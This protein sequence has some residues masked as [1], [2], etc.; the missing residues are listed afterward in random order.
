MDVH[1]GSMDSSST[2]ETVNATSR[3]S[4]LIATIA[5]TEAAI[6][7]ASDI[8]DSTLAHAD[9]HSENRLS[10]E[11]EHPTITSSGMKTKNLPDTCPIEEHIL[12][13]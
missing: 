5:A 8:I 6:R 4:N 2:S 11:V 1:R 7:I 13:N 12:I 10:L 9:E 3:N